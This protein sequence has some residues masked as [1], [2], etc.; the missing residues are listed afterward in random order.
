MKQRGVPQPVAVKPLAACEAVLAA[1]LV[2]VFGVVI[3]VGVAGGKVQI[4]DRTG[5]EL[6]AADVKAGGAGRV[7]HVFEQFV[8]DEGIDEAVDVEILLDALAASGGQRRFGLAEEIL[9][10]PLLRGSGVGGVVEAEEQVVIGGVEGNRVAVP[11]IRLVFQQE[12]V[13]VFEQIH[14][15]FAD[16]HRLGQQIAAAVHAVEV[17]FCEFARRDV[18]HPDFG[19]EVVGQ[20]VPQHRLVVQVRQQAPLFRAAHSEH[21]FF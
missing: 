14:A 1:A 9:H 18:V 13:A 2:V 7:V 17:Q 15:R 6:A 19:R 20:L 4:P 12:L 5:V 11:G 8:D 21:V 10:P 3:G 16:F